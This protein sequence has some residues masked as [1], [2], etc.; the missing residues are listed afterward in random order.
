M[1]PHSNKKLNPVEL[2]QSTKSDT[3]AIELTASEA[4]TALSVLA[5]AADG[6]ISEEE[7]QTLAANH[8]RLFRSYSGPHFQELFKK[9]LKLSR[10]YT[11]AEVFAA[12]K[13]ALTPQLRETA[14]AIAADLVLV[15]GIFTAQE[16]DFLL[17]LSEALDIPD[18]LSKNIIEVMTLKNCGEN[19]RG[20]RAIKHLP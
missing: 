19:F 4:L 2:F 16:Q 8:I 17:E 3:S 15:D 6:K 14:F 1:P 18:E 11:P 20:D 13:N 10:Q 9:V 5:V 7:R 12:A